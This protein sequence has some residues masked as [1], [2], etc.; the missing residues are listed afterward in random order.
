M[1]GD[2][3][4]EVVRV[5]RAAGAA[6]VH[7]AADFAPYGSRRDAAVEQA[8]GEHGIA[9][10]RTGSPYAVAP[11]RITKDD[12]TGYRVFT[13]FFR[14]WTEH[15]WRAPAPEPSD[16]PWLRPAG[17]THRI[18]EVAPPAGVRLPAARRAGRPRAVA[19]VPGR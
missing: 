18:P 8:L 1:R 2:P 5:A 19:A 9:L 14:A 4:T 3:A 17:R 12:G 16:V 11:G 10:V 15:G 7:V 6:T 13:P